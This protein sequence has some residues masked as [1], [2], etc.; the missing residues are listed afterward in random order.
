MAILTLICALNLVFLL[1]VL[2]LVWRMRWR[3]IRLRETLRMEYPSSLWPQFESMTR[4]YRLLDGKADLPNLRHWAASPDFLLHLVLH[5]QEHAPR[6]IVECG[7]G[8]STIATALALRAF[9]ID[10]HIYSIDCYEPSV[11]AVRSQLRRHDLERFVTPI[12][13]PLAPRRYDGVDR[14]F[15]WYD[16]PPGVIPDGIDLL[17]VDGPSAVQ[18]PDARYPAGPEL[19]PKLSRAAHIFIDDADRP[20]ETEMVRRWRALYPN[21]SVRKLPAEKGCSDLFF[22]DEA[23]PAAELVSV[24]A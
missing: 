8:S 16:L 5:I 23:R 14:S 22:L 12:F 21:L 10:G 1:A 20:A 15:D 13:V 11:K 2:G 4:L 18:D 17:V 9:G 3:I 7:S 6:R 19:L 24:P